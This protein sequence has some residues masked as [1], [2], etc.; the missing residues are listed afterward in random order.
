MRAAATTDRPLVAGVGVSHAD[1]ILFPAIPATKLDLA[2]YYESVARW[3]LPDLID[4]PLTLVHCPKGVPANGARK[5]I[6]CVFM[7]HAKVWGPSAIR[8][9]KIREKTKTG[10]Y[11]IADTV[12]ALVGL[13]QMDVLEIHTW[14]SRFTRVEQPDRIVIDLDPGERVAWSTVTAA[15]RTVRELLRVLDLESFVKSTGG[16]GLHVVVP[17]TP[18][19]DWSECLTFA[20]AFAQAMVRR[21]HGQFTER[22][23]RIGRD[24]KILIDYLRNNRTNTSIAAY[25]TRAR[26]DAP[27]SLPLAWSDLSATTRPDHFTIATVTERLRK[28]R[29]DPWRA[30]WTTRQ[31]LPV[32]AT[33]ALDAM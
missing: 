14:N 20:R 21:S 24:D 1:R 33:R 23:A 13:A 7:K 32:N 16:K 15:A 19:A 30:Y 3:M 5:G 9:V 2:R 29:T 31:R 18:H 28:R 17:L 10:D 12:E 4:R 26:P 6:D 11:L 22:F 27:V 25:S 8:R